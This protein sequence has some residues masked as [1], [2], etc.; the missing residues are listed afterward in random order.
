MVSQPKKYKT[1]QIVKILVKA[2]NQIKESN[3]NT[4]FS[5]RSV[6]F[7]ERGSIL[8]G[9]KFAYAESSVLSP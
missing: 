3:N 6:V 5:G 9:E 2:N 4:Y 8:V 1:K 7:S